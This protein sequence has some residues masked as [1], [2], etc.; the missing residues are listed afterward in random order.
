MKRTIYKFSLTTSIVLALTV[1]TQPSYAAIST[2]GDVNPAN[3]A[4]WTPSTSGYIG[5]TE[6]GTMYI[7]NGSDVID[8][9]GYISYSLGSTGTVTVNGSGSTWTNGSGLTVGMYGDGTL[10]IINGGATS[11]GNGGSTIGSQSDSTGEVTVDGA[12]STW[13]NSQG[14]TVGYLGNGKLDIT[15]GGNVV[16]NGDMFDDDD[17]TA[18]SYNSIG[19]ASNSTGT[20]TVNGSGS[21]WKMGHKLNVGSSGSGTLNITDGGLVSVS[22]VS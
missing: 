12:G 10:D 2:T 15:N 4:T 19:S 1:L 7:T 20:V 3:P 5:P 11:I 8:H 21:Y 18:V 14:L 17:L 16:S 9:V 6:T 22:G 13:T